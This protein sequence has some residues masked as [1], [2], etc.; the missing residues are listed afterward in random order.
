MLVEGESDARPILNVVGQPVALGP[1]R[2]DLMPLVERWLND[3]TILA[4]LDVPLR[5]LT[6]EA[7]EKQYQETDA[8]QAQVWFTVYER[9]AL[10]PWASAACGTS[11]T[12]SGPPSS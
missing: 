11:T 5:P 3:F 9:M 12:R 1:Q 2:R 7:E 6:R 4:P 10:A 8:N